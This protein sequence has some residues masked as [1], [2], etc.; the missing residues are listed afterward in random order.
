VIA[1]TALVGVFLAALGLGT[2]WRTPALDKIV[3]AKAP[4][5]QTDDDDLTTG[6]IVFVPDTGDR[7]RQNE[8]DNATW[9]VREIGTVSCPD[10]LNG[11]S[12]GRAGAGPVTR[13]DIIRESFRKTGR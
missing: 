12:P 6:S 1:A 2:G 13:L 10:A 5:S 8:I 3:L 9:R 7:C 11:R 4:P